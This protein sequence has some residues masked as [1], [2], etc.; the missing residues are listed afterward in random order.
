VTVLEGWGATE[1]TGGVTLNLP[2][3]NRVGTV[4]RP[5]PGT[6][7]RIG[8]GQEILVKSPS[9]FPGYWHDESATADAFDPDGWLHTGDLGRLDDGY[10]TITGRKKDIIITAGGKNVA[11]ALLEDLLRAHWLIDQCILVGDRMPYV[12]AMITLDPDFLAQ[13]QRDHDKTHVAD[14]AGLRDDPDLVA[15]VQHAVDDA[16]LAVSAAEAIKRFRILAHPFVVGDE[17]TP[18]QKVRRA[19][20]LAKLTD[21]VAA[22]YPPPTRTGD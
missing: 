8:P 19:H 13:W 3:A 2:A 21:E 10:V 9:V 14:L 20:V 16:N 15:T 4:G 1:T 12:G 18:T 5:L 11:P 22:L 7:V 6:T 17:L